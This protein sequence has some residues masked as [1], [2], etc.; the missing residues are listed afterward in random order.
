M[1]PN[2]SH[3]N[4]KSNPSKDAPI[5]PTK[6]HKNKP[7]RRR[8]SPPPQRH[9][10]PPRTTTASTTID[11]TSPIP[12]RSAPITTTHHLRLP[13]PGRGAPTIVPLT[14]TSTGA[15]TDIF[16]D[17]LPSVDV[18]IQ[19]R[20]LQYIQR[21]AEESL[22]TYCV[23]SFPAETK[24]RG[25]T[26]QEVVELNKIARLVSDKVPGLFPGQIAKIVELQDILDVV[27]RIRHIAVH[28]QFVKTAILWGLV[29][30]VGKIAELVVGDRELAQEMR[31]F[32]RIFKSE[33][34]DLGR[35]RGGE[36]EKERFKSTVEGRIKGVLDA[37]VV[38]HPTLV[39]GSRKD[40]PVELED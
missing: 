11:L 15:I 8:R 14:I 24:G 38:I 37:K 5:N 20:L 21:R 1:A 30:C 19:L 3:P 32:D 31:T 18:P 27:Q 36:R 12:N 28:R 7:R 16:L 4:H 22:Y 10:T 39:L 17:N 2:R 34:M 26:C 29:Q 13:N 6:I 23:R 40:L 33:T 25:F 35:D 9:Q